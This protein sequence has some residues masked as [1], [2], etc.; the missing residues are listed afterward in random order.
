MKVTLIVEIEAEKEIPELCDLVGGRIWTMLDGKR[1]VDV[2]IA[3]ED[4]KIALRFAS[5][6]CGDA[7][8]NGS[9][10]PG[11]LYGY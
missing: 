11:Q 2:R 4:E 6:V 5:I 7:A 8:S 1:D 3:S 10:E 9:I